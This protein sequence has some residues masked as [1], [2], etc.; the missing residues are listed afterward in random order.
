[1][2]LHAFWYIFLPKTRP[3][4]KNFLV[5]DL[6]GNR[7]FLQTYSNVPKDNITGKSA[8]GLS[9][10]KDGVVFAILIVVLL[11]KPTGI[12]GRPQTEKV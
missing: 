6:L 8:V 10:W 12:L 1:M 11:V 3:P 5:I 9:I 2:K 4:L 7:N